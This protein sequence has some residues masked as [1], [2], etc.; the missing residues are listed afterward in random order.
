[1]LQRIAGEG[2][3]AGASRQHKAAGHGILMAPQIDCCALSDLLDRPVPPGRV[4]LA[5]A[6]RL[7]LSRRLVAHERLAALDQP[8]CQVVQLKQAK[9]KLQKHRDLKPLNIITRK[10]EG[11]SPRCR[12][13]C[14]AYA[15]STS[16]SLKTSANSSV[17]NLTTSMFTED[18][19][20][21]HVLLRLGVCIIKPANESQQRVKK[22]ASPFASPHD[23]VATHALG[24]P[25]V[26]PHRL[27]VPNV[28]ETLSITTKHGLNPSL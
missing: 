9:E 27:A 10:P 15:P 6:A 1:M 11:S 17:N 13:W 2:S 4:R 3:R 26:E 25:K 20:D 21:V 14:S 8:D 19:L 18:G 12:W 24:Q 7:D 28:Q 16:R 23:A 22:P 5:D